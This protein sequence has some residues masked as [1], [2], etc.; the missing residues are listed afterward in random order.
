MTAATATQPT[1]SLGDRY[2]EVSVILLTVVALALGWLL[3]A[4]V[5]GRATPFEAAGIR[6]EVPQ[7]WLRTTD[8]AGEVLH[9][10]N[11]AS[12][13]FGTTYVIEVL[14]V[15]AGTTEA[16]VVSV[17]TLQRGQ[18]LTAYR[19][20]DQ[21][22]ATVNGRPAHRVNSVYVESDADLTFKELPQV[23]RAVEF[24][25]RSGDNA[26]IVSYRAA[27]ANYEADF[28]RFRQF[29]SSLQF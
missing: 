2:A 19:V 29:L 20:L 5:E 4:S 9:V 27:E 15:P 16:Q 17:L 7:G 21:L 25:F 10:T 28:G 12:A 14:P 3:R 11:P 6:G 22:P 13:G 26:I 8:E 1:R 24:I 23:V 18:N